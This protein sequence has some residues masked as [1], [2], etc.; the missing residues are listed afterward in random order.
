MEIIYRKEAKEKG[1]KY[2][3]TRKSCINQHISQRR[4][5]TGVCLGCE[6][7]QRDRSQKELSR[8]YREAH[9][10]EFKEYQ[11]QWY[12]DNKE[13]ANSTRRRYRENNPKKIKQIRD[14][15]NKKFRKANPSYGGD[16]FR[17]NPEKSKEYSKK[18]YARKS[19][20]NWRKNNKGHLN[21]LTRKRQK[22]IKIATP[23]W[24]NQN[25]I[26]QIYIKSAQRSLNEK[27][28]YHVD[29][30]IPIQNKLVCGLHVPEN[31]QIILK[32]ENLSKGNKF[33][34]DADF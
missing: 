11:R 9:G 8:R 28:E 2:Y 13:S 5:V 14:T 19:R 6:Q 16:W 24:A 22:R 27:L 32:K 15:N 23:I 17:S 26:R 18:D 21:Y 33:T 20:A 12:H 1:L 10:E 31:L 25:N 3:F 4:T 29:H 7:E 34:L 30:I